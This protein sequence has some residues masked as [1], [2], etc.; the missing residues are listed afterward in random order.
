MKITLKTGN[1]TWVTGWFKS[2]LLKVSGMS[3]K[4]TISVMMKVAAMYLY[5]KFT[6]F[7]KVLLKNF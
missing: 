7:A 2:T 6:K 5:V 4:K 3:K 1:N